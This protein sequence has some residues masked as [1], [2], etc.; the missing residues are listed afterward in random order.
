M[1]HTVEPEGFDD[2]ARSLISGQ[3]EHNQK[4][5]GSACD[6]IITP[7]PGELSFEICKD[8]LGE[9][10]VVSD[11]EAL[12]AVRFAYQEMKLVVEP[13]GAAALAGLIKCANRF[14]GD[15]IAVI[16]SGGNVDP[17]MFNSAISAE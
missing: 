3:R 7:Q 5:S 4:T 1:L 16:L 13:G 11:K 10:I 9:G 15:N 14:E 2:Y 8:I 6:A 12:D 17:D